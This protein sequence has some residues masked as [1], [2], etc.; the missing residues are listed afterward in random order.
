MTI[1]ILIPV[2]NEERRVEKGV[3]TADEYMEKIYPGR[4]RI[5]VVDNASTD[6]TPEIMRSLEKQFKNVFYLRIPEK[7]VGAAF[8]AGVK[9]NPSDIIGYM[10]VD[11]STDL[12]HL[13]ET[14]KIFELEPDVKIVNGSRLSR[15]SQTTGRKKVGISLLMD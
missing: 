8:R 9:E 5:T 11:L 14:I 13:A 6:K 4:Y 7:G 2:Y 15:N 10:D 1:N 3:R 12:K